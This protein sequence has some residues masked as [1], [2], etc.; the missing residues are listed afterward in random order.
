MRKFSLLLALTLSAVLLTGCRPA[1]CSYQVVRGA[2]MGTSYTVKYIDP[3]GRDFSG[4]IQAVLDS[5]DA[6]MSTYKPASTIMQANRARRLV[7]H[8][9]LFWE[10]F[11][12][13]KKVWKI[14]DGA[15]DP[16]VFPL[17]VTSGFGPSVSLPYPPDSVCRYVGFEKV[18]RR[19]DT[20]MKM[21]SL[22]WLDF[23]A[24]A[25]GYGVDR[26][27]EWLER[28]GIRRYLV[29]VGGEL[30]GRGKSCRNSYWRVG[31]NTPSPEAAP[32]DVV[33]LILLRN[34]AI[35]TSGSYR[36]F[37]VHHQDTLTH[38][39]DPRRCG[40]IHTPV[41]SVSVIAPTCALA[42]AL[43]TAL[44]VMPVDSARA[45]V[46]RLPHT[47]AFWILRNGRKGF[48]YRSTFL[49][50]SRMVGL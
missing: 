20:L 10:V 8:D 3:E 4:D 21:D 6:S 23:G 18:W 12:L 36:Q 17:V 43:A 48:T 31:I 38:I 50:R 16:T 9:P 19:G 42:D 15:F 2:T 45:V 1:V 25:K 22:V 24:I 14:T 30:R 41:V 7:I 46:E 34:E 32:T 39:I 44:M 49:F 40:T 29:E 27:G 11:D 13:A 35:A 47:G 37:E 26:V 33:Q 28:H 5:V